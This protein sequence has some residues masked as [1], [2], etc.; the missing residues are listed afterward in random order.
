VYRFA[1][2]PGSADGDRGGL[3]GYHGGVHAAQFV[4]DLAVDRGARTIAVVQRRAIAREDIDNHRL[5]G[6]QLARTQVVTIR[7]LRPSGDNRRRVRVTA[8]QQEHVDRRAQ[9]LGCQR[10]AVHQQHAVGPS[11]GPADRLASHLHRG[12]GGLLGLLQPLDLLFVLAPPLQ[13]APLRIAFH[14]DA[15]FLH[16]VSEQQRERAVGDRAADAPSPQ[17]FRDGLGR[18]R[19]PVARQSALR[20]EIRGA[21]DLVRASVAAGPLHFDVPQNE[22]RFRPPVDRQFNQGRRVAHQETDPPVKRAVDRRNA[23]QHA[24]VGGRKGGRW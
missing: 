24:G 21:V 13:D 11:L 18:R 3:G 16:L 4:G 9:T 15:G 10:L 7:P 23:R 1:R 8:L 12:L 2:D 17:A 5:F 20:R 6:S 14:C 22:K 19:F